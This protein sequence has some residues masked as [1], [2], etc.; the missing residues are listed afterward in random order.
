MS[1]I[2]KELKQAISSGNHYDLFDALADNGLETSQLRKDMENA[3]TPKGQFE[4]MKKH[5]ENYL[6]K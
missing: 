5:A 6:A 4:A 1:T 3:T 2:K